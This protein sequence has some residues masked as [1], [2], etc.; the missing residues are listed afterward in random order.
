MEVAAVKAWAVYYSK[1]Y[2]KSLQSFQKIY[3]NWKATN[4]TSYSAMLMNYSNCLISNRRENKSKEI[5]SEALDSCNDYAQAQ[6]ISVRLLIDTLKE[7]KVDDTPSYASEISLKATK[8]VAKTIK[9]KLN[10]KPSEPSQV[11]S[12]RKIEWKDR[13]LLND[14]KPNLRY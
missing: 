11:L 10:G 12:D 2:Q 3:D 13:H 9:K 8:K 6:D 14:K 4:A 1:D 7:L 5:L